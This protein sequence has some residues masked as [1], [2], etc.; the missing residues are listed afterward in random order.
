MSSTDN[1]IAAGSDYHKFL[2]LQG[3]EEHSKLT[4]HQIEAT[5]EQTRALQNELRENNRVQSE[6]AHTSR[7]MVQSLE[8][9]N[10]QLD[11]IN[12]NIQQGFAGLG[13]LFDWRL[14]TVISL[15]EQQEITL[16]QICDML[17]CPRKTQA[18][19]DKDD[20]RKA[21]RSALKM[22]DGDAIQKEYLSH[23]MSFYENAKEKNP[24]DYTLSFEIGLLLLQDFNQPEKALEHFHRAALVASSSEDADYESKA[25]FYNARAHELLGNLEDAYQSIST[26]K[27]LRPETPVTVYECARYGALTRKTDDA[28]RNIEFLLRSNLLGGKLALADTQAWWAKISNSPDFDSVRPML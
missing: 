23:A 9:V 14:K 25:Y 22:P 1:W 5:K 3:M 13:A 17:R 20:A 12:Y 21:W 16:R 7:E 6:I 2:E 15:L 27:S 11:D 10:F 18:E 26:A 24:L 28:V 4:R 19:E 8:D